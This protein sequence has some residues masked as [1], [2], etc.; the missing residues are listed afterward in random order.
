[1]MWLQAAGNFR[2]RSVQL[3][4]VSPTRGTHP[5]T[6]THT[7]HLSSP[8]TPFCP[9][10]HVPFLSGGPQQYRPLHDSSSGEFIEGGAGIPAPCQTRLL[11]A[12]SKILTP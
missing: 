9:S 2:S 7:S 12:P 4:M 8:C 3:V 1:M 11:C 10:P 6:P 5:Q